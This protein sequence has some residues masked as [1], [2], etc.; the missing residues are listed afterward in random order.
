M[1]FAF[2]RDWTNKL[3]FQ[4]ASPAAQPV[5]A[6]PVMTSQTLELGDVD[7]RAIWQALVRKRALVVVP[8]VAALVLSLM[9]VNVITPRYK[10]EARI[11]IDGR[12]NVFLRPNGERSEDRA[13]V[14]AE[15]V[16]SQVQLLLSRDLAR[17]VIKQ[18]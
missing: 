4:F 9:A 11:L 13:T 12:E 10:S 2:W 7:L 14:D 1:R 3:P 16:T 15:A 18:N 8:T 5:S 6:R 17:D